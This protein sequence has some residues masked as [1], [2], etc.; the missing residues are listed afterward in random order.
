MF[1]EADFV[2]GP[3][4]ALV[5][6]PD[7]RIGNR[8]FGDPEHP[9]W[10]S[11]IDQRFFTSDIDQKMYRKNLQVIKNI[12]DANP[13]CRFMFWSLA[14]RE[15]YNRAAGHYQESGQYRHPVWNLEEAEAEVGDAAISLTALRDHDLAEFM[16]KDSQL[17]PTTIGYE[18]LWRV[19]DDL[20][21]GRDVDVERHLADMW[22]TTTIPVLDFPQRTILTGASGWIQT[23][24]YY[25]KKGMLRLG[26]NIELVSDF[27]RIP[28]NDAGNV[29]LVW[30][31][32]LSKHSLEDEDAGFQRE[33]GVLLEMVDRGY[34]P[35]VLTWESY[36]WAAIRKEYRFRGKDPES[37]HQLDRRLRQ[38]TGPEV[39]VISNAPGRPGIIQEADVELDTAVRG[40]MPTFL[41][42]ESVM[43]AVG[44]RVTKGMLAPSAAPV[45]DATVSSGAA[46]GG[47]H[48]R[49]GRS[50]LASRVARKMARRF[51]RR[52]HQ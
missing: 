50:R 26:S 21:S 44:G 52:R 49:P 40:P 47:S 13:Q 24:E 36:A 33:L 31:S 9:N 2:K 12:R 43:R 45:I 22:R 38:E 41:G 34:K 23:L 11:G 15:Y 10:H 19:I 17:H 35:R 32:K 27:S 48:V 5:L 51:G 6:I 29:R 7:F 39:Q 4:P 8:T 25:R 16:Y 3:A 46:G 18:F 28:R 1:S 30:I 42:I 14:G 37:P 20:S